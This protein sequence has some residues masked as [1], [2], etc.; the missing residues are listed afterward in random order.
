MAS[1]ALGPPP[2][3]GLRPLAATDLDNAENGENLARPEKR[4]K[5]ERSSSRSG[6]TA[7]QRSV[8]LR[9]RARTDEGFTLVEILVA[10][11]MLVVVMSAMGP[12][13]YGAMRLTGVTDQRSQATNLAVAAT[14][15]MR[16]L[17]YGEVGFYTTEPECGNNSEAPVTLT[18]P[19]PLDALPATTLE[20]HTTF[21]IVRCVYWSASSMPGNSQAYK[22]TLVKVSW[23]GPG[24]TLAVSQTSA[25]YPGGYA[26][27]ASVT[28][29]TL[30]VPQGDLPPTCTASTDA[31][32]PSSMIDVSWTPAV[33]TSPSYYVVYYTTYSPNGSITAGSDPYTTSPAVYGTSTVL[34]VGPATAYYLQ[35]SAVSPDG[36]M[37]APSATCSA[38]T[39][40]P[41]GGGTTT[42]T[43]PTPTTT[44]TVPTGSS[45]TAAAS[46]TAVSLTLGAGTVDYTATAPAS[47]ATN[48][49]AGSNDPV[50]SQPTL[51][52]PGADSFVSITAASQIAEANQ[53]GSSYACAGVLSSGDSLSGGSATAPC[54]VSGSGSGGVSLNIFGLPG[55]GAAI[56]TLVAGLTLEINSATSW[57]SGNAGGSSLIGSASLSGATVTV[58]PLGGLI[59]AQTITLNLPAT[60]ATPTD[61][62]KAITDA[63]GGDPTVSSL[64]TP[65][66]TALAPV[67]TLTGDAQST[68]GGVLTVSA[69]H[70]GLLGTGGTGDLAVSTVG[71]NQLQPVTTTTT[72]TTS[73]T[74]TTTTTVPTCSINSLVVNP[75]QG[76]NGSGVALTSLGTLADESSFQLSVNVNSGCGQVEV[77]YAPSGCLPGASGCATFYAVMT[78]TSGTF[79]GS[80]GT[81]ATIWQVGTTTFTVFTGTNPVAYSPLT[82]Q[83]VILCT[84]KGTTGQC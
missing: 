29:T 40:G 20:G 30:S 59:P 24:G 72:S 52:V 28:T 45:D 76:S 15:Q 34:T 16:S 74:S 66:Q 27:P 4:G 70:I 38:T 31:T 25:L 51:S 37:S 83:Q 39:T 3:V 17:P 60:L 64:A 2:R 13:F 78:G 46:A 7:D 77:G 33:G 71:P 82:Q 42:T 62:V 10:T 8:P 47:T 54:S 21:T 69:L 68:S 81:A 23:P 35:V 80:A 12:L 67:V 61:L 56:N 44:T 6:D 75:S 79:Y 1:P 41:G 26:S 55:V 57:A 22:Q 43:T 36:T 58:T 48:D 53:D 19:G 32:N 73:T 14:E 63:I 65:L 50:V 5:P 18:S 11:T 84:E 9:R 49:G